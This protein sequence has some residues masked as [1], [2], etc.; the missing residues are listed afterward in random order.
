MEGKSKPTE[1]LDTHLDFQ[2]PPTAGR[3]NSR[4]GLQGKTVWDWLQLLIVPM[5]LSLITVG[6]AW[7]QND[8]QQE[9]EERRAESDRKIEAQRAQE[10]ALQAYL[11]QMGQL[12]LN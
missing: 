10:A 1:K 6:F 11:D 2:P 3:R 12:L 4:W 9:I 8:Q 7:Q 5:V